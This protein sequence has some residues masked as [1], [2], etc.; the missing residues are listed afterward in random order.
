MFLLTKEVLVWCLWI[1]YTILKPIVWC[2]RKVPFLRPALGLI[3]V[4]FTFVFFKI[5]I[6]I[7][8]LMRRIWILSFPSLKHPTGN[9]LS[10]CN[11]VD[12]SFHPMADFTP[13]P[14][15]KVYA[16]PPNFNLNTAISMCNCS[17][18]VYENFPVVQHELEKE[19]FDISKTRAIHYFN[20]CGFVA[21][22]GDNVVVV[23]RGTDLLNVMHMITDLRFGMIDLNALDEA[24][25]TVGGSIAVSRG[26]EAEPEGKMGRVHY[27]FVK[28]LRVEKRNSSRQPSSNNSSTK[29]KHGN[30]FMEQAAG[31]LQ[32]L[33]IYAAEPVDRRYTGRRER[34]ISA[35]QQAVNAIDELFDINS[36]GQVYITGH[37]LGGA[38]ALIFLAQAIFEKKPWAIGHH[39]KM[40][41]CGQP[42]VGDAT[43]SE[44][45]KPYEANI[46]RLCLNNDIIARLAPSKLDFEEFI[47]TFLFSKGG[48]LIYN[49]HYVDNPGSLIFFAG[50]SGK[51]KINPPNGL[52]PMEFA[53]LNGIMDP[54]IIRRMAKESSMRIYSRFLFPYFLNDHFPHDVIWMLQTVRDIDSG[55]IKPPW[56]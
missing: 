39:F 38:V 14:T 1:I 30:S 21:K 3:S 24:D 33:W 32:R 49:H 6:W 2:L 55:E 16:F 43:F 40:Y 29:I 45:M 25:E 50:T 13:Y 26:M 53:K 18:L 47:P 20:T 8:R 37:S 31:L 34:N 28:A 4:L 46:F 22:N 5:L 35:Y 48:K 36:G 52:P 27:G 44:F 10:I 15:G 42:R 41:T 12:P 7:D 17:K 19:G 23:F 51:V 54:N 9:H 11:I 56:L